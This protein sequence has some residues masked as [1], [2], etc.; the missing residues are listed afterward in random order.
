MAEFAAKKTCASSL[1][2][3][4]AGGPDGEVELPPG[5][6]DGDVLEEADAE[7]LGDRV[8]ETV[9]EIVGE[10]VGLLVTLRQTFNAAW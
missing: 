6:L 2:G 1:I 4:L 9:G 10:I 7:A 8:C 5:G 3:L